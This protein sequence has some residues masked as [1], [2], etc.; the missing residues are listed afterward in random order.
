[1]ELLLDQAERI[2]REAQGIV[3]RLRKINPTANRPQK[4]FEE[5][6]R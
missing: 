3:E 5:V 2:I 1:M 6:K 4:V